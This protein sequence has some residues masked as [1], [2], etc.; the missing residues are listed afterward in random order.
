MSSMCNSHKHA[1]LETARIAHSG[2]LHL[3]VDRAC[4]SCSPPVHWQFI[5][6]DLSRVPPGIERWDVAV[7]KVRC[8]HLHIPSG[9]LC[10]CCPSSQ[11]RRIAYRAM[12]RLTP[13]AMPLMQHYRS[14]GL[15]TT[16]MV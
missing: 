13:S 10:T 15:R 3:S 14:L 9:L 1:H 2:T 5:D 4:L 12:L 6:H 7:P 16:W 8:Q 11:L